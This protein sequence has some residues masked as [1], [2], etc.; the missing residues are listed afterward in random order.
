MKQ[1][2][3]MTVKQLKSELKTRNVS[4]S[5]NKDELVK[6]LEDLEIVEAEILNSD[7]ISKIKSKIHIGY[8]ANRNTPILS[9]G[10]ISIL[11]IGTSGGALLYSDE[12]INF[13]GGDQEYEL[14]D[15]DV[16]QTISYAQTLVNL[17]HPDWEGRLSGTIEEKNTADSIKYNFSLAPNN[18]IRPLNVSKNHLFATLAYKYSAGK[19]IFCVPKPHPDPLCFRCID[20]FCLAS[21][22]ALQRYTLSCKKVLIFFLGSSQ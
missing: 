3:E 10:V 20:T 4:Q 6:K 21:T 22:C 11:L 14:I 2:R 18:P 19:S 1:W 7:I 12:I 8:N 16:E 9:L 15:F 13:I 17:G 5:G